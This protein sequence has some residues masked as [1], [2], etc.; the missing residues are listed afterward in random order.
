MFD[1]R[2]MLLLTVVMAGTGQTG[3]PANQEQADDAQS[4]AAFEVASVKPARHGQN[5]QGLSISGDSEAPSQGASPWPR[6]LPMK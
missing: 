3:T 4:P 1:W 2:S 6:I 5:A